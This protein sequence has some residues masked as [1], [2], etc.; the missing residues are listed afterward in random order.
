MKPT[1][2]LLSTLLFTML[3]VSPLRGST[4]C[5]NDYIAPVAICDAHTVVALSNNGTAK[6]YAV[7][8]DDG[9]YDNCHIHSYEA[10]RMT[11]GWCPPWV[12]DDTQ[13]R[14]Y[15]EFCCEDV[16]QTIWVVLRVTDEHGN[17][18]EC[19]AEVTV[20]DNTSPHMICPPNIT[21]SCGFWFSPDALH[22][23]YNRTFG[24][25]A[26]N[27][28]D[29]LPIYINDPGNSYYSQP[30]YWGIDGTVGGG[31]CGGNNNVWIT[32]PE[33]IDYRNSCGVGIIKR[34][35]Y[36]ETNYWSDWCYQTITVKDFTSN[37]YYINWPHDYVADACQYTPDDVDPEDLP[38]PYN[39]PSING[40]SQGGCGL[41]GYAHD[42]LVFTFSDGACKK[43]LREW[44]VIDWCKYQPNNPWSPGLW[45]HTQVI[46]LMNNVAPV[47]V[48]GCH[49]IEVD[50]YL[51]NCKGRYY[52]QPKV[53]DD[54]T[55]NEHLEWD[56]KID[57][58]ADGSYNISKEG[59]GQPTVD[60]VLPY[61]WHKILWNVSDACGN[62]KSCSY[63][64]HVKD[65]KPPTP[66][67]YYGLS[68]VV[69][70]VGGMVT[71]WAKDFNASSYDNCTPEYKLRYSFSSNPFETSRTFTCDD[72]GTVPIQIWVHD[73]FGNAD[74]CTTFIKINDNEDACS[75][76]NQVQGLVTTFTDVAVPQTSAAMYKIMPDLSLDQDDLTATSDATGHFL[77][78]FGTTA[79]DRMIMLSRE[80]K[81]LEGI[82]T[83]DLINLQAHLSGETPLTEAHQLYAADLDGNGRVGA[84]D[85]LLLKKALLGGFKLNSYQG[86]LSW[87][88]FG[89]PCDPNSPL[90]LLDQVCHNGVEVDH[91]GTFPMVTSFK[92]LKMGDINAD[93][94]NMAFNLTPRTSSSLP[95]AVRYDQNNHSIEF[96]STRT[97]DMYGLQFSVNILNTKVSEGALPVQ[98]A[99]LGKDVDGYT[100]ISW[101]Q[102][103][104]V[105]V[106]EG[107]VLFTLDND[108]EDFELA[109]L[110]VRA[111]ESLYPEAYTRELDNE[112]IELIPYVE[113]RAQAAFET[114]LSP[115]PFT[116]YTTLEVLIPTGEEF[117]VSVFNMNGQ[118]V[119]NRKYASETPRAE[120]IIGNQVAAVPGVY[121]YKVTS[122]LG[123]LSGKFIRQ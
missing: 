90:D 39:K 69:M 59:N 120:I 20:Q 46:K 3:I 40:G 100:N 105:K 122:A 91:E 108:S 115:N 113:Y 43:I 64:V 6:L 28:A 25:V 75:G 14:P 99:H 116:D 11:Q 80:G 83:L 93:M 52:E 101:G 109:D 45:K 12:A 81:A 49:D 103:T 70:P 68:T 106:N 111:E 16:G 57:L 114:R 89:D 87:V 66:I 58:W 47:F 10:R 73:E 30:H 95:I 5:Y 97:E 18:N 22:N 79:Y 33:V 56:Y 102:T 110:M 9:S 121:Y 85:L 21:V 60:E 67:C 53:Y 26:V 38:A 78:G 41:I 32:I 24:T 84:N 34:K 86:D 50:G 44:T 35:F 117:Y 65:A 76:M 23:P 98:T 8:I 54:C 48:D 63:K 27:G 29:R 4:G 15:V 88:F 17:Y 37:N 94:V 118:E 123:E 71:I 19:M 96:I 107:E 1:F 36:V 119:F 92:A 7:D 13:F 74:Y 72:L 104:P 112:M 2:T 82:S 31:Y 77:L 62:Y 55:T 61:G 42:D 51:P